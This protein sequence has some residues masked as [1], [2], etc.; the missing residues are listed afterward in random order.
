MTITPP[1][2]HE[3]ARKLSIAGIFF[4]SVIAYAHNTGL[5]L[6]NTY[7][8]P[9]SDIAEENN[10]WRAPVKASNPWRK[11][12]QKPEM[13]FRKKAEFFPKYNYKKTDN[14]IPNSK[15]ENDNQVVAPSTNVFKYSF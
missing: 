12:K 8:T 9:L 14:L 10:H 13:T 6:P 2:S 5:I 15:P 11:N 4:I 7:R 1:L 3:T